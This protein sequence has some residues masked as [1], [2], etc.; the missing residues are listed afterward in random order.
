MWGTQQQPGEELWHMVS[1][2]KLLIKGDQPGPGDGCTCSHRLPL[3][4]KMFSWQSV[5]SHRTQI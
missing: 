5:F 3:A 1:A 2:T 4:T